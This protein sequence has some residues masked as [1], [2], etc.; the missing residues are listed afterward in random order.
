MINLYNL[1]TKHNMIKLDR[2]AQITTTNRL[3]ALTIKSKVKFIS[4]TY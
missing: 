3:L 1:K 4:S 2:Q